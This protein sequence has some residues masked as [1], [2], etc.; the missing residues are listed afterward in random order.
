[1]LDTQQRDVHINRSRKQSDVSAELENKQIHNL[2]IIQLSAKVYIPLKLKKKK[3]IY[4]Y[5]LFTNPEKLLRH[6]T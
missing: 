2:K 1:M 4:F 3:R 5:N 6:T